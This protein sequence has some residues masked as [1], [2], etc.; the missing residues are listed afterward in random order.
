MRVVEE[1]KEYVRS[2][3]WYHFGDP[4]EILKGYRI[5][6]YLRVVPSEEMTR[7]EEAKKVKAEARRIHREK[8]KFAKERRKGE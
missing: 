6:D 1:G 5:M 8:V 2:H 7:R 4:H 3:P